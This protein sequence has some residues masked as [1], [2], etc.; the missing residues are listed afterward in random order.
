[1]KRYHLTLFS[2]VILMV[3]LPYLLAGLASGPNFVWT[4]F[5]LNPLDGAAY[6]AKMQQGWEG[7]W[8]FTLPFTAEPGDGVYIFLFYLFLGHLARW[9]GLPIVIV[10]HLFRILGA[11]LLLAALLRFFSI[12]FRGR[13]DLYR[14][15]GCLAAIGSGMGW[16]VIFTGLL[17]SDA[18]VA[19]TYPF[20]SMFANPHFPLGLAG[21]IYAFILLMKEEA[22]PFSFDRFLEGKWKVLLVLA[23][24]GLALSIVLPFGVVI[25]GVVAAAWT[26]WGWVETRKLDWLPVAAFGLLGGPSLLY[27]FWVAQT[28]P[29]LSGWNAQNITLTP[30]VWDVALA[31]SPALLLAFP[32]LVRLWHEKSHPARRV[33]IPWFA[34]GLLLIYLPFSLQR[35]FMLGLYIPTAALAVLGLDWLSVRVPRRARLFTRLLIGLSVPTNLALIMILLIGALSHAPELYLTHDEYAAFR[36]IQAN[37]PAKALVLASPRMSLWIPGFTGRRVVYGHPYETVNAAQEEQAV[38][39][40]FAAPTA[41]TAFLAARKVGYIIFGGEPKKNSPLDLS[42]LKPVYESGA[43]QVFKVT[44]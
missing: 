43:V 12:V 4:G 24:L 19:E 40:F 32:G 3:T 36:W 22:V 11:G 1:M 31:L 35:R 10:F 23:I 33:L 20:L 37:T 34:L 9:I 15:A 6:L 27:Q 39:A 44:P 2:I 7:A 21:V 41:D 8:R 29:V 17:T 18:W 13:P 30:P 38:E 14:L 26:I 25:A 16:L 28:H 5:L 42:A